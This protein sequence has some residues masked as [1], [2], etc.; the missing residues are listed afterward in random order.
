MASAAFIAATAA[1][2][3]GAETSVATVVVAAGIL[4]TDWQPEALPQVVQI[5]AQA[6]KQPW[7]RALFLSSQGG[8]Y[9]NRLAWHD[10]QVVAYLIADR[11]ADEMTLQNIGV[12]PAWQGRGIG[13]LLVNDLQQRAKQQGVGQIFLEVRAS[14]QTAISLYRRTGFK[15]YGRRKGYYRPLPGHSETED[16]LLMCWHA[17]RD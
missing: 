3:A 17:G 8:R 7:G 4:L 14:N 1:L 13:Y 15:I 11:V 9:C 6:Q 16:A 12:A 10:E 5:D 2:V